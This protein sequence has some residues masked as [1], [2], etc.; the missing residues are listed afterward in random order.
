MA[1]R[2]FLPRNDGTSI[3][4]SSTS[5]TT[6]PLA[7]NFCGDEFSDCKAGKLVTGELAAAVVGTSGG[8][9]SAT[10]PVSRAVSAAGTTW[11]AIGLGLT[12]ADTTGASPP[13]TTSGVPPTS[14]G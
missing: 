9:R 7:G 12:A 14:Q 11:A 6:V 2:R 1:T 10:L 4:P 3:P 5:R 8:A 13:A